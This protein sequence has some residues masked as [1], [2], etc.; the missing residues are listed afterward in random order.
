MSRG[1]RRVERIMPNSKQAFSLMF[2]G[3]AT[4]SFL[5]PMVVYKAKNIY[6]N[7]KKD[8]PKGKN[9]LDSFEEML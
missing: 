4:G 8:G 3:D 6:E 2:C 9:I 1:L 7:W 5:P